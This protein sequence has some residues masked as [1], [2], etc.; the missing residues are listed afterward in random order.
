VAAPLTET[1]NQNNILH[2]SHP[3]VFVIEQTTFVPP[4]TINVSIPHTVHHV[5][6]SPFIYQ[7]PYTTLFWSTY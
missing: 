7:L 5:P 2:G 1:Y 3:V 4:N 6:H